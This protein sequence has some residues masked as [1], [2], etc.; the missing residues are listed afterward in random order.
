MAWHNKKASHHF[1]GSFDN[2]SILRACLDTTYF[3]E[4]E[5]LLLKVLQIKVNVS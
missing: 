5:K 3:A 1:I 4:Y 2:K